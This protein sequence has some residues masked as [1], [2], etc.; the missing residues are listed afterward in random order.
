MS[1]TVHQ[2]A[3]DCAAMHCCTTPMYAAIALC[4][5]RDAAASALREASSV[6]LLR[7]T[8]LPGMGTTPC[9]QP[10]SKAADVPAR[11][12]PK[13]LRAGLPEPGRWRGVLR[14]GIVFQAPPGHTFLTAQMSASLSA[15]FAIPHR[16]YAEPLIA[17]EGT[18]RHHIY[19]L[20]TPQEAT[21]SAESAIANACLRWLPLLEQGNALLHF[22][23]LS[24]RAADALQSALSEHL[25]VPD[26]A[27]RE[28]AELDARVASDVT[29][30]ARIRLASR[31]VELLTAISTAPTSLCPWLAGNVVGIEVSA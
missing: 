18:D 31:R 19:A 21:K 22:V 20:I 7:R 17:R 16:G 29:G 25:P 13:F 27:V 8:L 24:G 30:A 5:S 2:H 10:T 14:G 6:G 3:A 1:S 9:Y 28:L 15:E 4:C 11:L 23:T 12:A 26:N